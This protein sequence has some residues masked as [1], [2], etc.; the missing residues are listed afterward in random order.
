M[1]K[2]KKPSK[3]SLKKAKK[4]KK[5]SGTIKLDHITKI[6][7]HANL[8]IHIEKGKV[9]K[10][11][12]DVFESARFF[13]SLV[14]CRR[15]DEASPLTSR[16]CGICSPSHALTSIL[17]TEDAFGVKVS[18]QTD[19]LRDLL[20]YG[21][22]FQNHVLHLYILALPDY[23]GFE[24][25]IA[26]ASK[27]RDEVQMALKLKQ[28]GN[29]LVTAV[30][31]REIHPI[32]AVVGGFSVIPEQR[33]LDELLGKFKSMRHYAL[34]TVELFSKIEYPALRRKSQAFA[35][36]NDTHSFYKG[37]INCV[38]G[39]CLPE[40][41]YQDV[42]EEHIKK[43]STAKVVLYRE[44]PF[45]NGAL[46]RMLINGGSLSEG[47][48]KYAKR[49]DFQNPF[50]N[51]I[52]QAIEVLHC[53]DRIIEIL[54]ALRVKPEL[55]AEFTPRA[56]RGIAF[57]EAPR[58]LLVHDY[59]YDANGHIMKANIITP[60]AQN[61]KQMEEDLKVMLPPMIKAGMPEKKIKRNIE[62]LIRAY[63]PCFSCS[64]HFLKMKMRVG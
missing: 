64:A 52:A 34:K 10:A 55:P 41:N 36:V 25:A 3:S 60:T 57:T 40:K 61:L 32:T 51:N 53:F 13:E 21:T 26:M 15:Y 38:G 2:K 46:A 19:K 14:L 56:G 5:T 23:L 42:F 6:E 22:V 28:L 54:Q 59:T 45:C 31:G 47:A 62:M 48:K 20:L 1:A 49:L 16:I 7:G 9:K 39:T 58:G 37:K 12:L 17:A 33:R 18:E 8:T 35:L 27:Y 43:G 44:K 63:D 50:H 11:K 30:G 24:S 4:A 29:E